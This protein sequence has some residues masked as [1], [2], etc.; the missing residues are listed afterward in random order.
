MFKKQLNCDNH[1]EVLEL[2]CGRGGLYRWLL[3]K[4][5]KALSY[6]GV[7]FDDVAIERCSYAFTDKNAKFIVQ[8]VVKSAS[9]FEKAYD[10]IV[11][12]N[13]LPYVTNINSLARKIAN[14]SLLER[15]LIAVVDPV[16]SPFWEEKFGG[17]VIAIRKPE[18]VQKV[19]SAVGLEIVEYGIL[20]SLSFC[21]FLFFPLSNAIVMKRTK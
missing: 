13:V 20:Y 14:A 15:G 1:L 6:L 17:F 2:G 7:D 12:I 16:P 18:I 3:Q 21:G 8:D 4:R 19:F 11:C 9:I 10:L 5:P